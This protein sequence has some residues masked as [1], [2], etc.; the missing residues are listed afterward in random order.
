LR[1]QLFC[2]YVLGLYFT[3]LSLPAQKLRVEH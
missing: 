2:A 1:A 3:G